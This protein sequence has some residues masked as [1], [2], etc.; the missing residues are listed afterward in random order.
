MVDRCYRAM[1]TRDSLWE[2]ILCDILSLSQTE[3]IVTHDYAYRTT[4]V[5]VSRRLHRVWPTV[6]QPE[7]PKTVTI[8]PS[9]GMKYAQK[10]A[11]Y[12]AE[13]KSWYSLRNTI[14]SFNKSAK[15]PKKEA[16]DNAGKRPGRGFTFAYLATTLALVSVNLRKIHSF[17]REFLNI[18]P[19]KVKTRA[20]RRTDLFKRL[21]QTAAV[22]KETH[23]PPE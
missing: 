5:P 12:T 1:L 14:E 3:F 19:R 4:N 18:L 15:T 16:I 17:I 6:P 22:R 11:Y 20:P 9:K 8:P 23:S 2:R 10:F 13:W 7:T 21:F